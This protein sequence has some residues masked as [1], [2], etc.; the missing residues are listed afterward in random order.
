MKRFIILLTILLFIFTLASCHGT[1]KGDK[2]KT[3]IKV[4][5]TFSLDKE[6]NIVFWSKNDSNNEQKMV[7]ERAIKEFETYYPNIKVSMVSYF[8]Y[9]SIYTDVITNIATDT[10]PNVCITYPDHVATYLSGDNV[11]M[12]LDELMAS[13]KYGFGGSMVKFDG[14]SENGV[15]E[16]FLEE[17]IIDN[18]QYTIPFMR[19]SEACYVNATLVR[20]LGFEIPEILTWDF[21]WE[22]A[23][24]AKEVYPQDDFI[25]MIYK[26]TDNMTIQMAKQYGIPFS[27]D[28]G[29]VLLFNDQMTDL[30]LEL[31]EYAL[32]KKGNYRLFDTFK[33]VSY[34]GNFYNRG[35]CIFAIDST[36]GATWL[37]SKAPLI[38]IP[39]SEIANFE[40]IVMPVPQANA[41]D[42]QMISQGPSLCIFNKEDGGE[43][44][45]SWLFLQYLLTKDIQISYSQ[46]EGYIPVTHQ[47]LNDPDYLAYLNHADDGT[48]LYYSVKLA[49]SKLVTE[50][51]DKTFIT[52]V[53]N[54][55]SLLR[56]AAGY[57]V[58]SL[59]KAKYNGSKENIEKLYEDTISLYKLNEIT[60]EGESV[61]G[62]LP[63]ESIILIVVL[64]VFWIGLAVY[65]IIFLVRKKKFNQTNNV[66]SVEKRV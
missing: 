20:S 28:D 40:T 12:P 16:K 44:I 64:C 19:S 47:A 48:V 45:A 7:Y 57:L 1:K 13:S 32:P 61:S 26:S 59:Y 43:V 25:P 55:S 35:K 21:V 41:D 42:V 36:A 46:T 60:N 18:T 62:P 6:Y 29:N 37:G 53:F 2:A 56:S 34:P 17:G 66:K 23:R 4:N 30:L 49:A 15:A 65:E 63:V 5:D 58:E 27:D 52:A 31:S 54:G 38:E 8:D 33:R 39:K 14:I 22:V 51:I 50:Y 24:K 3:E 9:P 11:I 10:T